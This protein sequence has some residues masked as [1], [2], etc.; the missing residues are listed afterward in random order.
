MAKKIRTSPPFGQFLKDLRERKGLSL[1]EV[2]EATGIPNAYLCQLETGARKKLPA[3]ERLRIIADYYNVSIQELL[4]KAGYYESK[5]IEETFEQKIEK[6]FL[7]VVNDP[8]F[9][10]GTRVKKEYDLD[11]K[12]FIIEMYEKVTGKKLL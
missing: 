12:R 9:K 5:E 6:A 8:S 10:Y 3:P 7:H 11:A 1:D 2:E 4:E